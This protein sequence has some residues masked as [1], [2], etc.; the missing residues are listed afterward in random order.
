MG[1]FLV[2]LLLLTGVTVMGLAMAELA[3]RV[4]APQYLDFQSVTDYSDLT[5]RTLKPGISNKLI[6][7]A[8]GE[9]AFHMTTNSL[10]LRSAHEVSFQ[11][12]GK[13]RRVLALGDSYTF[14]FGVE[15]DETYPAFLEKLLNSGPANQYTFQVINA[16]F[17]DG[18]APDSEYLYLRET[19]VKF[20]PSVVTLG[21]CVV[22]D[23]VDINRNMWLLDGNGRLNGIRNPNDRYI[24]YFFRRSALLAAVKAY[25]LPPKVEEKNDEP[26]DQKTLNKVNFL[27]SEIHRM[28]KEKGFTFLLVIIPPLQVALDRNYKGNWNEIRQRLILFCR[29]NNILYLDLAGGLEEK[30]FFTGKVHFS[31]EG[32]KRVAEMIYNKL[33]SNGIYKHGPAKER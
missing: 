15:G 5:V 31:K 26:L 3:F 21:F 8:N 13:T 32:N 24:P 1:K 18:T 16:G 19:G 30:S 22:N 12:P 7:P 29:E 2:N 14:G 27:L 23:L 4:I 33:V 25:F 28:G 6:H 11:L 20:S 17:A 10:G 9:P